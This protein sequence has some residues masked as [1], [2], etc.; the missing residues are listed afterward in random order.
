MI[1]GAKM[2]SIFSVQEITVSLWLFY[3]PRH[4]YTNPSVISF[5][6]EGKGIK[7]VLVILFL[8]IWPWY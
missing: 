3:G 4:R 8:E 5:G 6:S 2:V 1:P 7:S